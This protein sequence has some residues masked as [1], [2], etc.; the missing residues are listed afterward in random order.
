MMRTRPEWSPGGSTTRG[1]RPTC[2]S[3]A[4]RRTSSPQP[5]ATWRAATRSP[6]WRLPGRRSRLAA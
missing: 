3:H 1:C 2:R 5:C 6:L 4:A